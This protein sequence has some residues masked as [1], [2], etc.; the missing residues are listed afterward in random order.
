M[1]NTTLEA[2]LERVEDFLQQHPDISESTFGRMAIG[3]NLI[4]SRLRAGKDITTKKLDRLLTFMANYKDEI[5]AKASTNNEAQRP[6][7]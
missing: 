3:N 4:V 7:V 2:V 6:T 1:A 5:P